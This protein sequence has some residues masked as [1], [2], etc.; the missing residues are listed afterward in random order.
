MRIQKQQFFAE[1]LDDGRTR[2]AYHYI[3]QREGSGEILLWSQEDSLR[4][5]VAA[6]ER[7]LERL[8]KAEGA[9]ADTFGT[10]P[11]PAEGPAGPPKTGE[12]NDF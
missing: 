7:E 1:I 9:A 6:A 3:I 8:V 12:S 5:A 4:N 11:S 2:R 10:S